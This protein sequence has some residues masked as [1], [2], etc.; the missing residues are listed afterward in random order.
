VK[1]GL[2]VLKN[3]ST[4]MVSLTAGTGVMRL[5]AQAS[6]GARKTC[7][8]VAGICIGIGVL[9]SPIAAMVTLTVGLGGMRLTAQTGA[10][11][12][13]HKRGDSSV[14]VVPIVLQRAVAVT[15]N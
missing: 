10:R 11:P 5:T 12:M 14:T 15:L 13:L 6:V 1:V 4:A 8:C 3:P 7:S 2:S 9:Q